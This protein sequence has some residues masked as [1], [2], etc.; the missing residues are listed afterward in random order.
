MTVLP[1]PMSRPELGQAFDYAAS[2]IE[3]AA[4]RLWPEE[5]AHLGEH[6]PSA[7]GYVR[8]V[9]VGDRL[10]FAKVSFLGISLVS[11]LRGARGDWPAVREA[12]R[13]YVTGP[14]SLLVREAAQLRQLAALGSP[15]VCGVAGVC[16]GVLFTEQVK[17]PTLADMLLV[18]PGDTAELLACPLEELRELHR[19][20]RALKLEPSGVIGERSISATFLRKFNGISGRTY[21][22]GLGADRCAPADRA[23]VVD[24]LSR[25]IGRLHRLRLGLLPAS[26][27]TFAYGDLKPEHVLFPDGPDARPVLLDPGLLQAA[28]AV[29][30]A[31]LISRTV[32]LLAGHQPSEETVG[33]IVEGLNTFAAARTLRLSAPARRVWLRDLMALWLMDTVNILSTYLSAPSAL[34]LP[35][36]GL[37]LAARAVEVCRLVESVSAVLVTGTE[38]NR[39]WDSMMESAVAVAS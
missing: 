33:Q 29:D 11:L 31:K 24:L 5:P 22:T 13:E 15:R 2:Q 12:Q 27:D 34:P 28:P 30:T 37:A 26:R 23:E 8:R 19:S 38:P 10:L 32:L 14:D 1:T 4:G 39:A 18:R 36:Q 9:Q 35:R 21:V 16:D 17:G 25:S 3:G 7:T 20:N 6:V